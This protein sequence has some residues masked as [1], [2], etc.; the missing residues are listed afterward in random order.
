MSIIRWN[1]ARELLS[2]ERE[3]NRFFNSFGDRFR[4]Q[5]SEESGEGY[6]NAVWMPLTDIVEKDGAYELH[7]DLPGI[8][9]KDVKISFSDGEL[10]ISGERSQGKVS[11]NDKCHREER[12]YGKFYRSF[13]LPREIKADQISAEFNNGELSVSVP[14][15]EE[16][17]PKEIEIKMK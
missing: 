17:K 2:M 10:K 16:V 12:M 1:P 11:K 9:K 7:I 15:A 3:L 13:R 14:K 6:E 4:S 5:N 8:D